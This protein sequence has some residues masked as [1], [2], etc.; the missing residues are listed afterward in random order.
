MKALEQLKELLGK[1]IEEELGGSQQLTEEEVADWKQDM[2]EAETFTLLRDEWYMEGW[3][4]VFDSCLREFFGEK[5]EE[6][7]GSQRYY[8]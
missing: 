7:V 4:E 6:R 2:L 3:D 5:D 1:W 8:S